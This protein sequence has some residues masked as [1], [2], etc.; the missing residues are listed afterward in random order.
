MWLASP[1]FEQ[2]PILPWPRLGPCRQCLLLVPNRQAR[3][4]QNT[5]IA[6]FVSL[7][8]TPYPYVYSF[9]CIAPS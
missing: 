8:L 1:S 2:I 5:S 6:L 3:T 4:L 9:V 7:A